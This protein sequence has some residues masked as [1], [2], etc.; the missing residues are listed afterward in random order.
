MEIRKKKNPVARSHGT[1][2][3]LC[4]H[5]AGGRSTGAPNRQCQLQKNDLGA[6]V[7]LELLLMCHGPITHRGWSCING[8]EDRKERPRQEPKDQ[9]CVVKLNRPCKSRGRTLSQGQGPH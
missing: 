2:E 5:Q 1:K 8:C 9:V 4:H 7:A 6:L 3:G